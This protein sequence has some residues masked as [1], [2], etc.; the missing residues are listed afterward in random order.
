[1]KCII[2]G[3]NVKVF[4]RA[5]HSL[6]KIGE[7]LYLEPLEHGLA[8]RTVN[9]S[10]SAYA[11]FVFAPSFFQHYDDGSGQL[12]SQ[13]SEEDVLRCKINMKSCL[14]VF[15]SL[16]TIERTVDRCKISLNLQ[17]SRLVF[18]LYCRHGI[19]K[20][21]NLSFIECE[22]LQAVFSKDLCPNAFT[23]QAKLLSDIV[24]NFQ[25]NQ[26]EVTLIMKPDKVLLK[27]YVEDEPDPKKVVHTELGLDP[28]EFDHFQSGVD[29]E[30]T[31][32]LKE[33]RAILAFAE[34]TALPVSAHFESAGK[35]IVFSIDSD[36]NFE[37]NIVL[38]TLA[39][40]LSTQDNATQQS[41]QNSQPINRSMPSTAAKR[42]SYSS[43]KSSVSSTS[44]GRR[45]SGENLERKMASGDAVKERQE[46]SSASKLD[47]STEGF[48]VIK[49]MM[50]VN[51]GGEGSTRN[52]RVN[53]LTRTEEDPWAQP[54]TSSP[55]IPLQNNKH[56]LHSVGADTS[57]PEVT[58][59]GS[60]EDDEEDMV[61]GTP[62]SKKFKSLFF[63]L[64][65]ASSQA[66]QQKEAP[67]LAEETDD[68]D[69]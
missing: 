37:G 39:E 27:N 34:V 69:S 5:I 47:E 53:L 10:R 33:L 23:A 32:C 42:T 38:A 46:K 58:P 68:E 65:Q 3:I 11:C 52:G 15:K 36:P 25:N 45:V 51:N 54:S 14:T 1:M 13:D 44:F 63:G 29:T 6:A 49:P 41:T 24:L 66:S 28:I 59:P 2:P 19:V 22:T 60:D 21:H 16:S 9:S 67:V 48:R 12:N 50:G 7:E 57:M 8:L 64:S 56:L 26:E 4:G 20:T 35:P 18:Q 62:P 31:F 17:E 30:V 40:D 43:K 61:P 55:V